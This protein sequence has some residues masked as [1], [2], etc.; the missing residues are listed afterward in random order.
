[1]ARARKEGGLLGI[2]L[3]ILLELILLLA[4]G[5]T[6]FGG[7]RGIL[8]STLTLTLI[9]VLYHDLPGFWLWER[10]LLLGSAAGIIILLMINH[11]AEESHAISGLAG[12]LISLVMFGAFITPVLA[13]LIW[14]L[15]VGT[16]L[17][18]RRRKQEVLWGFA[19]PIWRAL[20]GL[21]MIIYGNFL[22]S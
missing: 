9:N 1:M 6:L 18:P 8:G 19:P 14:A 12:G 21:G 15:I 16:G 7:I 5:M 4:A 22:T 13:L 17:I 3:I 10:P 2:V 11:K 20:L